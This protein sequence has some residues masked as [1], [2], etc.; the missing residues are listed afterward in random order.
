ML[1]K[2][3]KY[4]IINIVYGDVMVSTLHQKYKLQVVD[5]RFGH[6]K[7]ARIKINADNEELAL[8]A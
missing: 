3:R 6:L 2:K 7:K 1:I 5:G 4:C 8:A